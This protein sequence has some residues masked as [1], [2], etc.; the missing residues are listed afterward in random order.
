LRLRSE[1]AP[2][3]RATMQSGKSLDS[4]EEMSASDPGWVIFWTR[5]SNRDGILIK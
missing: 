4:W 2:T 1:T 5:E 3:K